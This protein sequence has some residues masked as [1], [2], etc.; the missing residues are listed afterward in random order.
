LYAERIVVTKDVTLSAPS[1]T[2]SIQ[3]KTTQPYESTVT[4]RP[5]A[6]LKLENVSIRHS[7]PSV[8]NNYSIFCQ[9]GTLEI[10]NC[11]ISSATGSGIGMEGGTALISDSRI[12]GCKGSGIVVAG[13]LSLDTPELDVD[14][15]TAP[16]VRLS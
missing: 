1:A 9:G 7:S 10:A 13:A 8:A 11:D 2:A 12:Q 16:K 4:V 14:A 5:G 3:W 6:R 15:S